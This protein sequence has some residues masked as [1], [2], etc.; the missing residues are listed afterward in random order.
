VVAVGASLAGAALILVEEAFARPLA[1][2]QVAL[3]G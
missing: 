2:L 1:M 3:A